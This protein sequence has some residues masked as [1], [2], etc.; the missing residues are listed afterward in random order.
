G[1]NNEVR[2]L[3]AQRADVAATD[4][5]GWTLLHHA[6]MY[7]RHFIVKM[8]L[9]A[10]ADLTA[11]T[12]NTGETP[13]HLCSS[14]PFFPYNYWIVDILLEAGADPSVKTQDTGETPLHVAARMGGN[15]IV[16]MLLSASADPN[17]E[18]QATGETPLDLAATK[19]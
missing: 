2:Q 13:L 6:A 4:V 14:Q 12:K 17:V 1:K 11:K 3:I 19:R 18:S 15:E 9:N 7:D 16:S 10:S 8:L 5:R